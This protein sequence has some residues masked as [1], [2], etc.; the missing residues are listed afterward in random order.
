MLASKIIFFGQEQ[1]IGGDRV[2]SPIRGTSKAREKSQ[3]ASSLKEESRTQQN[4][5]LDNASFYFSE[6][7][8]GNIS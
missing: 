2:S 1:V 5:T 4:E 7:F 8:A 6:L 3:R